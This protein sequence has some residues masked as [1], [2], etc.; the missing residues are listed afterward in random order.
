MQGFVSH[1]KNY[2]HYPNNIKPLNIFQ[3]MG[4]MIMI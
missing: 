1:S 3:Q 2:A 4:D